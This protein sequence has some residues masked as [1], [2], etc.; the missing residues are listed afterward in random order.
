[1]YIYTLFAYKNKTPMR[2]KYEKQCPNCG[3]GFKARRLNQKFCNIRCKAAFHNAKN[4]QFNLQY[5]D[6]SSSIHDILWNNRELLRA[7][8]GKEVN[9]KDFQ[10]IGFEMR[11]M[12]HYKTNPNSKENTFFCYDHAYKF[13]KDGVLKIFKP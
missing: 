11:Y 1:M 10:N 8:T 4:R 6:V 5:D 12:T 13:V 9:K 2:A 3:E 7:N